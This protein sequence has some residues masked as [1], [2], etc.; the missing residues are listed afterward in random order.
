M[1]SPTAPM[2]DKALEKVE[3]VSIRSSEGDKEYLLDAASFA[4]TLVN[5][6]HLPYQIPNVKEKVHK[7]TIKKS[8][9]KDCILR[10]PTIDFKNL[11]QRGLQPYTSS[12]QIC[13]IKVIKVFDFLPL[14]GGETR[15][16][17]VIKKVIN[18]Q[19]NRM[20]HILKSFSKELYLPVK[21]PVGKLLSPMMFHDNQTVIIVACMYASLCTTVHL[22]TYHEV[23]VEELDRSL[24]LAYLIKHPNNKSRS[25]VMNVIHNGLH[26]KNIDYDAIRK[27]KRGLKKRL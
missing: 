24:L 22:N 6:E 21:K 25:V 26:N 14:S 20:S 19:F 2:T 5:K 9:S 3:I 17:N 27:Y 12:I 10:N 4:T 11:N 23:G 8:K 7:N 13:E 16:L 18:N 15:R 1:S